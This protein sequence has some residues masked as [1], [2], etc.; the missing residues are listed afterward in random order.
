MS[1]PEID[2]QTATFES[3]VNAAVG[4]MIQT[5]D[6]KWALP[7]TVDKSNEA[8]VFAINAERRRR[9]TQSAYTRTSQENARLK[10]EVNHLA[11]GW[12][13]DFAATLPVDTQAELEELKYA[14]PEKWRARLNELES[15]RKAKFQGK[16]EEITQKAKGESEIE[17]RTRAIEE[18]ATAHPDITLTDDVIQNDIPPRFTNELK[19]GKVTFAQFLENC[20]EYLSKGRVVKPL[21]DKPNSQPNIGD[22]AGSD[23]PSS[24]AVAAKSKK[25]YNDEIF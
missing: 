10:A 5:E 22:V 14:D 17:Y 1:T 13:A 3:T 8:L 23:H 24:D 25:T 9:D 2:T 12:Q 7:D 20:A 4:A 19:A 6:G 16:R 21:E 11:E 15:D 18:F